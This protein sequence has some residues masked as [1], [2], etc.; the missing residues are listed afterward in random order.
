MTQFLIKEK[1]LIKVF[2]APPTEL[3][4]RCP[5]SFNWDMDCV[6]ADHSHNC[7]SDYKNGVDYAGI[8]VNPGNGDA[9]CSKLMDFYLL[10]KDLYEDKF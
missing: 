9:F 6:Y 4:T 1:D 2:T 7:K 5:F 8:T 10:T 3:K